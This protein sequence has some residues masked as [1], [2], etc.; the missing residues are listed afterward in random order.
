MNDFK[1]FKSYKYIC[2]VSKCTFIVLSSEA[3]S[4]YWPSEEKSTLRTAAECA[5]KTVD[6]PFLLK[7]NLQHDFRI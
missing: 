7:F 1:W 4:K 3:E 2:V 6:S 5:V